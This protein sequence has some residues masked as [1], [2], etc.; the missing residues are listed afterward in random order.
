MV[1]IVTAPPLWVAA[2]VWAIR[3]GDAIRRARLRAFVAGLL[4]S[5][6]AYGGHFALVHYLRALHLNRYDRADLTV[7]IG[8]LMF[9]AAFVGVV[10]SCFGRSYGRIC[11]IATGVLVGMVWWMTG[12]A[13]GFG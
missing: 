4:A 9:L 2:A 6:I 13:G 12:I 5:A 3:D 7:G 1:G 8:G 11:G 10:G